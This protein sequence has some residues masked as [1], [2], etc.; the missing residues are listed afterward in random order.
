[1]SSIQA[2]KAA[3]HYA[4]IAANTN[5]QCRDCRHGTRRGQSQ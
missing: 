1:M 5:Q 4:G 2:A 3:M